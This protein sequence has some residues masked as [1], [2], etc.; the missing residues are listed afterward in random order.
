VLTWKFRDQRS[1][2]PIGGRDL[3]LYQFLHAFLDTKSV[4]F[5]ACPGEAQVDWYDN[6][7]RATFAVIDY[8]TRNQRGFKTYT[9]D[10][11]GITAAEGPDDLYRANGA[12]PV[13]CNPSPDEDGTIAYYGMLSAV[14]FGDDLRRRSISAL[15]KAWERGHWHYRFG[16]PDAF[17][18]DVSEL[19][20]LGASNNLVRR[21][22]PWVHRALF[23]IDQGPML[24]HLANARS[25]LI[26][27]LIAEN[28]N[29]QRSLARLNAPDEFL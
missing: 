9:S 7:R 6:S 1:F 10:S 2:E 29:I 15:R 8:A 17:H 18:N 23:A 14:S 19:I 4:K 28:P 21:N 5:H 22:G 26:W 12:P 20:N 3:D 13:G 24:L 11:W 16:L 27:R 25:G